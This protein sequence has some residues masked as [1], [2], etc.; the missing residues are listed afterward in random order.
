MSSRGRCPAFKKCCHHTS[1]TLPIVMIT[2]IYITIY[3][4]V[5]DQFQCALTNSSHIIG[6]MSDPSSTEN[7]V[8]IAEQAKWLV[9]DSI[10]PENRNSCDSHWNQIVSFFE[11][12]SLHVPSEVTDETPSH[13]ACCITTRFEGAV[14]AG[15]FDNTRSATRS[16]WKCVVKCSNG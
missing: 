10:K 12:N 8:D 4:L 14:K 15:S 2:A 1:N 5:F 7:L 16:H 11:K 3:K 13:V 9:L 6:I